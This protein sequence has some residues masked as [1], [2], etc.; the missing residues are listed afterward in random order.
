MNRLQT[1]FDAVSCNFAFQK[2][3]GKEAISDQLLANDH[4]IKGLGTDNET[5]KQ[6]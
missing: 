5:K 3:S 1:A 6:A 2:L 4:S